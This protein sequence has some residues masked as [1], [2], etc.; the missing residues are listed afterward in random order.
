MTARVL[1]SQYVF[2]EAVAALR[3]AG[4]DVVA[5]LDDVPLSAAELR[6]AVAGADALVCLLSDRIDRELL[7]AAPRLGLVANVAVGYDNVDVDAATDA[8]VAVSNTPGVL[9][10]ATADLAFALILATARRIPEGD[11]FLRA[12]RYTHWK[13]DQEQVGADVHGQVLGIFGLG[14]IG[15]AVA[16]RAIGGFGMRVIY[17]SSRRL[18]AEQEQELGVGWVEL[19]ELL[20]TSD[21]LSLHGPL[22]EQTRHV[23]DARALAR[24]RPSAILVNTARGPLVDEAA[25]AAA[26]ADG[27]I[28]GAGLDVY[29]RE[30]EVHPGLLAQ[31]DRVVLLPHLGSATASTRRRMAAIAVGN[32]LDALGGERPRSL[33]NETVY[34]DVSRLR[35]AVGAAARRSTRG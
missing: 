20:S 11:A 14:C 2:P 16:R 34:D 31:R 24:M 6:R 5:R 13:L 7:A 30:P 33:V 9:T 17:H 12:G 10:E 21:F 15:R 35:G 32:V 22:T 19:D 25:L 18:P 8:G 4:L 26:L 1:V 28:A 23:I 3:E 27:T 29:E